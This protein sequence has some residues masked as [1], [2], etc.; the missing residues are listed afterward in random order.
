MLSR[1]PKN[2]HHPN[3]RGRGRSQ[4]VRSLN[5]PPSK[6]WVAPSAVARANANQSPSLWRLRLSC[7]RFALL[8]DVAQLVAR[9]L[10]KV[11]VAGSN[12][13]VRS[14][15]R[16]LDSTL[17]EELNLTAIFVWSGGREARQGTANPSTRVQIPSRPP[18][19]MQDCCR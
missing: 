8:A 9:N 5:V 11:Q 14:D 3:R 13:V 7:A 4:R 18:L 17:F 2:L 6:T 16:R 1:S 10:A 15:T 12:P 19:L